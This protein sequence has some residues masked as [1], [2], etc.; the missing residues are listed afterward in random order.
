MRTWHGSRREFLGLTGGALAGFATARRRAIAAP[1]ESQTADLVVYNAKVYTVDSRAPKAEAFA[2]TAGRFSAVGNS[3]E[4][5]ALAGKGT[6]TI[7]ARQMT[8]V[9]GFIDC[10]NHASGNVLLYG[11]L[12]SNPYV[13]EFVTSRALSISCAR[14]RGKRRSACG[15]KAT[16]STIRR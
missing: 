12:V 9:P 4:V 10:H 14:G 3:A 7:D 1:L 11:V 6:Q 2:V 8:I 15:W 13:V 16:F 5:K